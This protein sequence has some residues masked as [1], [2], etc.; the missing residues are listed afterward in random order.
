MPVPT[1]MLMYGYGHAVVVAHPQ[2][3][4]SSERKTP[5]LRALHGAEALVS[6]SLFLVAPSAWRGQLVQ[7]MANIAKGT[8]HVMQLL[9]QAQQ[10][11]TAANQQ[12]NAALTQ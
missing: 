7:H 11:N 6:F 2:L 8:Q 4:V 9:V 12:A 5:T 3:S 10:E 1:A